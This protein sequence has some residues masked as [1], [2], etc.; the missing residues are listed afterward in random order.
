MG[1]SEQL[2]LFGES[3]VS[4]GGCSKKHLD[5]I[6]R[7]IKENRRDGVDCP[8][9]DQSAKEWKKSVISTAVADLI[10]LVRLFKGKPIHISKFTKQRSNFYTLLYWD[11]IVPASNTDSSKRAA[12]LWSPT[13]KGIGFVYHKVQIE[14]YVYTYDNVPTEFEGPLISVQ[15]ALRHHF[16]YRELM[17]RPLT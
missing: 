7:Y 13:Q 1:E 9:C 10:R 12:G 6:R 8:A 17:G 5:D 14:K 3:E 11:L 2:H 16:D 15:E 4:T